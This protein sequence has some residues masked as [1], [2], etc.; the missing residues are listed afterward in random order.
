MTMS[1]LTEP[2]LCA[3][4][5]LKC[6]IVLYPFNSYNNTREG[7][8]TYCHRYGTLSLSALLFSKRMGELL[9]WVPWRTEK[10]WRKWFG[11]R[12]RFPCVSL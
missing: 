10:L 3:R 4:R 1:L 9:H 7:Q 2:L 12:G 6:Y 11:C 8:Y 5:G